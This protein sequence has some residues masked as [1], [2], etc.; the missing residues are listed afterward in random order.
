[1]GPGV[2]RAPGAGPMM[3]LGGMTTDSLREAEAALKAI[4]NA[5]NDAARR[6]AVADLER[7]LKKLRQARQKSS[8]PGAR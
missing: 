3:G 8:A 7:A 4:R 5:R 2:G 1:M 6:R